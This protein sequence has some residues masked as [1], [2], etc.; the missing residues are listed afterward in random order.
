[1][2]NMG[3]KDSRVDSYIEKSAPFAQ[4][5]LTHLRSLVHE[6][7]PEV[8][9]TVR[10]SF[11]H[12]DYKGILCSM[13]SFKQHCSFGFAKG[14]LM[15]DPHK[16]ISQMGETAMGHF[17]R[18]THLS[19]LPDDKILIE[20]IQEAVRLNEK[21]IRI[22]PKAKPAVK[23]ELE[24]P[25]YFMDAI[26]KNKKALKIFEE[27]SYSNKK[28]YVEWITDAKNED[29][30]QKRLTTAVEWMAEGKVRNWKYM[31]K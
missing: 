12:F 31:K 11:P 29:T 2:V 26:R 28:E 17:G 16:L 15:S 18:I 7:C 24:I 6:A 13:A 5:I 1:M 14:A 20:Y 8:V 3:T 27:F 30:R 10:W 23:K 25:S 9:E 19:D 21:G 22:P 4:P